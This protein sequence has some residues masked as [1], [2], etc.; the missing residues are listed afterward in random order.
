[1]KLLEDV[2]QAEVERIRE[3]LGKIEG[4]MDKYM[5]KNK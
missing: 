5:S 2:N 3:I 1:L 4:Y